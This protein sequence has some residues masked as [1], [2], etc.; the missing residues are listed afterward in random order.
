MIDTATNTVIA[1]IP[2]GGA[3]YTIAITPDGST[4]YA[5]D[6]GNADVFRIDTATNTASTIAIPV[7]AFG[8]AVAPD[9]RTAYVSASSMQAL[10]PIDTATG[11]VGTPIAIGSSPEG[12]GITPDG[13]T[14]WVT[15]VGSDTITPLDLASGTAGTPTPVGQSPMTIAITPDR[16]PT[17]AF[18]V[19]A[20][21]LTAALDAA[22]SSDPDGTV[23]G[24]AW[25][26][27]DGHTATGAQPTVSHTYAQ[28]GAYTV[29]LTV[30]DDEGC[31][32]A[33][34]FTGQ[35]A[36]CTGSPSARVTHT[37]TVAAPPAAAA[38]P[39]VTPATS[40]TPQPHQAIERFVL[41]Q[42]CVRP[43]ADGKARIG[44]HLRLAL[45][46]SVAIAVDRAVIAVN[47]QRCPKRNPSRHFDGKLRRVATQQDVGTHAAAASV[48]REVT[49]SFV[50]PPGLYRIA[51]RAHG[52][53]GELT[54]PA[55]R[56][57][58]VLAA[59]AR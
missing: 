14:I 16:S 47:A 6:L 49:R 58:R 13:R 51:V 39:P 32:R 41:A 45:P 37:V 2:T 52:P 29:T 33:L 7:A 5:T 34:V 3:P 31:S 50:L 54:R 42:R 21:D 17:A 56:W 35:T 23:A 44:L 38:P 57:V 26:F 8:V 43:G 12:L 27:G 59:R 25:D 1:T 46:G 28:P 10:L 9:G 24:Y 11:T 36:G 53:G 48:R 40:P 18:A 4:V 15:D 20:N 22:A 30:T 19:N 55:Y